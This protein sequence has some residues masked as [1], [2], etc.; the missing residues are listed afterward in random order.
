MANH[1]LIVCSSIKS[2][3]K[4]KLSQKYSRQPTDLNKGL[5]RQCQNRLNTA[6]EQAKCH[7]AASLLSKCESSS[8]QWKIINKFICTPK[9]QDISSI[10]VNQ[11][12][13]SNPPEIAK[14][15]NAFYASIGPTLANSVSNSNPY[16]NNLTDYEIN[17]LSSTPQE[18]EKNII[19]SKNAA[20]GYDCIK[21][22]VLKQAAHLIAGPISYL[23][24]L[25]FR[26]G[27]FSNSLKKIS[28]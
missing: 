15:L 23:I 3:R 26:Q 19:N 24:N 16:D 20:P 27:V 9:K 8:Q 5:S 21:A 17:L 10:I 13:I 14:H 4:N 11:T 2:K 28:S 7:H 6:I 1:G 22:I 12:E 18:V 25:S